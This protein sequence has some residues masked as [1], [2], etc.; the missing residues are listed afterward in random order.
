MEESRTRCGACVQLC[1]K[2]GLS[3]SMRMT[4]AQILD[5][6][7]KLVDAWC[8]RRCLYV[9]GF[10]LQGFPLHCL[11]TDGWGDFRMGL[12][13]AQ[14]FASKEMA[15]AELE[16]VNKLLAEMRSWHW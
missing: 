12:S 10:V 15:D 1:C 16:M 3:Y 11:H 13:K 14:Q 7:A 4:P 2:R 8:E 5:E 9:L 6:S